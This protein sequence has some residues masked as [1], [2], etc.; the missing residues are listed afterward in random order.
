MDKQPTKLQVLKESLKLLS[1][2]LNKS[3]SKGSFTLD[4]SYIIKIAITNFEQHV[5]ELK[6]E[7]NLSD[8][9]DH[10]TIEV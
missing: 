10:E 9:D 1:D 4:E 5:K 3:A 7:G 2:A 8:K 6:E